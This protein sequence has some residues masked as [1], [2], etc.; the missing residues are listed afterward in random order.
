MHTRV[1]N[2]G[3]D[4]ISLQVLSQSHVRW[5]RSSA[6][7]SSQHLSDSVSLRLSG[8]LLELAPV[9]VAGGV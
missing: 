4:Y 9:I 7:K 2:I 5:T 1:F 8:H 6:L 3:S